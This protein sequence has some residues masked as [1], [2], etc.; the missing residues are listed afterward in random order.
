[1][2]IFSVT[3]ANDIDGVGSAALIKMKYGIPSDNVF[4]TDYSKRGV[5]Y[6]DGK[7]GE[8]AAK[9][10][11]SLLFLTDLGM[12]DSLLEKYKEIIKK[13]KRGG[14]KVIWFDH[15]VWSEKE[16]REVA[17]LC[18]LAIVGENARY[19]GAEITYRNLKI[20]GKFAAD[21]V[22]LVHYSDFNLKPKEKKVGKLI[23]IYAMSIMLYN[24]LPTYEKRDRA[25]RHMVD[26]LSDSRFTDSRIIKDAGAFDRL[27]KRR[28]RKMLGH[29]YSAGGDASVGFS[30]N[31][32]STWGCGAIMEKTGCDL[33]IYV[34]IT[35]GTAHLRSRRCDTTI[36][37]RDM[38]GG[39]HP[40]ASGFPIKAKEFGDFKTEKD[41]RDFVG[42]LSAKIKSLY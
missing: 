29:L 4:F 6:V 1:M 34:N 26:V 42:F 40:H 20:E 39:G 13:V 15:H 36:L 24:T 10:G 8:M 23:G 14:G 9:K 7:I 27:N 31:L 12:N 33:A 11:V 37:S 22:S 38:G 3:H 19:C 32:Q 30:E 25:L 5:E 17:S 35:N 18:D 41:R 28:V 21:L 16:L 2:A